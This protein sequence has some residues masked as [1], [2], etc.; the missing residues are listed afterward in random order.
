MSTSRVQLALNVTDLDTA[1]RFYTD[2]FGVGPAKQRTGYANFV[3]ADPPLKLVLFEN[4]GASSPLNHLGVEVA[5]SDDVV[6]AAQRFEAA[7]MTHSFAESDRCCHAVQDKVWVDAP[8]VPLGGWEFY[9]VLADDP[10]QDTG[11]TDGVCCGGGVTEGSVCC[12]GGSC[13]A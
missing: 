10:D 11:A 8:D 12:G 13:G 3:V 7:G 5:S 2:L 6:T 4:P 9:T 1:T